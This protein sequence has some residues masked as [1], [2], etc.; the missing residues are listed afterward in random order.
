MRR[1]LPIGILCL[2]AAARPAASQSVLPS[3]FAGWNA[4]AAPV[5]VPSTGLDQILGPDTAIFREYFLK[6]L[7]QRAYN[8]GAQTAA[9]TLYRFRDPSSAYGAY[10]FLRNDSLAAADL[11]SFGAAASDRALVVVGDLLLDVAGRPARPT[12]ADLKQLVMS[13]DKIADHTPFPSI[14]EHLPEQGLVRRSEHYVLGPRALAQYAPLGADDWVGFDHSAETILARYRLAGKDATLLIVSYPTQ[15]IAAEKFAGMLRRF[16]FDP[17]GC[18]PPD[19]TLLFRKPCSSLIAVVV[20]AP[21]REAANQLLDQVQYVSEV[22]W[23]EPKHTL[24]DP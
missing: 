12:N 10:T 7:E 11:G 16:T 23:N 6:S 14:G 1:L 21:S 24:T 18:G 9:V 20:G 3:S 19:P 8:R 2:I 5:V 22:T 15:Q 13:L 4:A 17:P